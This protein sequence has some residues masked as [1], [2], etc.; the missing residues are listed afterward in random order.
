[1]FYNIK[2]QHRDV[3]LKFSTIRN[4]SIVDLPW[5]QCGSGSGNFLS[6]RIRIWIQGFDGQKIVKTTEKN[7]IFFYQTFQ[8]FIHKPP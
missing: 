8:F 4:T 3:A 7:L 6:I 5:F 2:G 1:M